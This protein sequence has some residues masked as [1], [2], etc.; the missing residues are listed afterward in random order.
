MRAILLLLLCLPVVS[1]AAETNWP[2]FRGPRGDGQS[3]NTGLPLTWSES[4]NIRWKTP[5]HGKGWSSPVV[6]D[7]QIWMT[8]ATEDGKQLFA[9]CVDAAS[10]RIVHDLQVFAPESPQFCH[11]YNS[12]ASSTPVI[13]Q[14][15][16]YVHFGVHG[17]ACLDTKTGAT[18]W[19]RTDLPCNHHR[20][21]GSSPILFENL[22]IVPFDG[23]DEQYIIALD[24]KT[25]ETVWKRDRAIDYGKNNNNGDWKKAYG[26]ATVIEVNGQPQLVSPSAGATIA[27]APRTGEELW[28]VTHGG[29]NAA[30]RPLFGHGRLYINTADGGFKLFAMRPD[31]SGDVTESH[32][33]WK[34][35]KNV[36]SRSSQLLIGDLIFMVNEASIA[37]CVDAMSGN[38]LWQHRF[39]G[40]YCASPL[41]ADGRIY[42]FSEFGMSP[43]IEPGREFKQLTDNKLDDGCMA[44][45]AITGKALILRTRT[46]LYRIEKP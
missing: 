21:A 38:Q 4:E 5:I 10:G 37:S 33:D 26:T 6:W 28:R 14:G 45:P 9:V 17:T 46:H 40:D 42:Y 3:P 30:A 7:D 32:V 36:A 12:Y 8:T 13:E 34:C 11:A 41:Y 15:R 25:G 18:I 1:Q 16:V 23:F 31:G 20:G 44:S 24:K 2:Q 29:M 27:Y 35:N 22:L 39:G 19:S 43:V